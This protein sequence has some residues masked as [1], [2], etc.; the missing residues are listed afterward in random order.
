MKTQKKK[1]GK[2]ENTKLE[3][4]KKFTGIMGFFSIWDSMSICERKP[5]K[6]PKTRNPKKQIPFQ[7]IDQIKKK[8][9]T[10]NTKEMKKTP[11]PQKKT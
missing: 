9:N 4:P 5:K 7:K 8:R 2:N 10:Q 6:S 1:L 3:P 11:S